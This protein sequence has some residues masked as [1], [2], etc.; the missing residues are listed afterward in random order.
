MN[1]ILKK[2][3]KLASGS[4]INSHRSTI[5]GARFLRFLRYNRFYIFVL[6]SLSLNCFS[7]PAISSVHKHYP[8]FE[9][10]PLLTDRM[11]SKIANYL[12]PLNHPIKATLDSIFSQSRVLENERTLVAAG[13][14]V[15]VP[16]LPNSYIIV[17]R[18]PEVPGYVFKFHLDSE[19]RSRK[20]RPHWVWLVRR[21]VEAKKIRK[22]IKRKKI[23]YF[24][25]PDKWLF[26]PP[27]YPFSSA[28]NPQPMIVV[29]TDMELVSNA[30]SKSMW[31]NGI[32]T[33]H[34]DELYSIIKHGYGG[35][36]VLYL[37]SNI[38]FTKN[39]KFA[40]IDTEGPQSDNLKLKFIKRF[41]SKEMQDHW[42]KLIQ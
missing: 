3:E 37:T 19:T 11:R 1:S 17:A 32:T 6:L 23:R 21:C 22:I 15:L 24:S 38:P 36:S 34:L 20:K 9:D 8:N 14:D 4:T 33:K 12:I 35:H 5:L 2:P 39:N 41:L 29:E 27:V 13:F 25:V 10:N 30:E 40:F 42:D 16:P 7:I 31:K 26:L 28:S 18:H